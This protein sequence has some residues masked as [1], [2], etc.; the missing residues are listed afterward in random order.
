MRIAP[1]RYH[2]RPR[3]TNSAL[4]DSATPAN[5][6]HAARTTKGAARAD[7]PTAA[8]AVRRSSGYTLTRHACLSIGTNG[9]RARILAR[10]IHVAILARIARLAHARIHDAAPV[11]L[12]RLSGRTTGASASVHADASYANLA[13]VTSN[14]IARIHARAD[15]TNL[16]VW[17]R[18][19]IA[20]RHALPRSAFQAC[21]ARDFGAYR[22]DAKP[23]LR[24]DFRGRTNEFPAAALRYARALVA[25]FSRGAD[26]AFVRGTIAIVVDAVASLSRGRIRLHA[27]EHAILTLHHPFATDSIFTSIARRAATG[28]CDTCDERRQIVDIVV[29]PGNEIF[30]A[31]VKRPI[32]HRAIVDQ[33]MNEWTRLIHIRI[34][35]R[36]AIE[37][38]VIGAQRI[39]L[40]FDDTFVKGDLAPGIIRVVLDVEHLDRSNA[41]RASEE[42]VQFGAGR[43]CARHVVPAKRIV[44]TSIALE[45]RE[46]K[47]ARGDEPFGRLRCA[48]QGIDVF[49]AVIEEPLETIALRNGRT[50]RLVQCGHVIC[51]REYGQNDRNSGLVHSV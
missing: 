45:H 3:T 22:F 10:S 20:R 42:L 11:W 50:I 9:A 34:V 49:A 31:E 16:A 7:K 27:R 5:F 2:G 18:D 15:T 19:P 36:L 25:G 17:A 32:R 48:R 14:R 29:T 33:Q 38:I 26:I 41:V 46:R 37:N 35:L 39:A 24:A 12:T 44:V 21:R 8:T 30:P 4:C 6:C 1:A 43:L 13:A 51:A 40:L 47:G 28:A 23:T